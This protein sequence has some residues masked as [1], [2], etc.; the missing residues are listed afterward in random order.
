MRVAAVGIYRRRF[1]HA[2][3]GAFAR[4]SGAMGILVLCIRSVM[5][6]AKGREGTCGFVGQFSEY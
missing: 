2:L 6:F 1:Y 4:K 3:F 5:L